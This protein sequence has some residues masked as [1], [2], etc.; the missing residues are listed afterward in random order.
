M[1]WIVYCCGR[2]WDWCGVVDGAAVIISG[3]E[4]EEGWRRE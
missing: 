4:K 3:G 1:E 2:E